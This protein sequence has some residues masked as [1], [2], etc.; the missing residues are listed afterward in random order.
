MEKRYNV[1]I[2]YDGY[3]IETTVSFPDSLDEQERFQWVLDDIMIDL[4]E[5]D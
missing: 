5:E 1:Y 3:S 4:T 2:E